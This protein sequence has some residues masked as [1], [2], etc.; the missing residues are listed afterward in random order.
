ME[1]ELAQSNDVVQSVDR[2]SAEEINSPGLGRPGE[3]VS[4]PGH[5]SAEEANRR[6]GPTG[7]VHSP[8]T[9]PDGAERRGLPVETQVV[10]R[11]LRT[12]KQPA[13]LDDFVCYGAR[14]QEPIS[15]STSLQKKSSGTRYPITHYVTCANFSAS[16]QNFIAA[17]TKVVE[18]R[19][20]H[21]AVKDA[22]WRKE[23]A[24]EITVLEKNE[25]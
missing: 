9:L 15:T 12:R 4:G 2:G 16:H 14:I 24:E 18:P 10:R 25:T 22:Q 1:Q 11:G 23:M 13:H 5:Q 19:F 8:T 3:K 6:E 7:R 21:E 17:I 20:Y